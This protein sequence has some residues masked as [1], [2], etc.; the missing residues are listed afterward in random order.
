MHLDVEGHSPEVDLLQ[1]VLEA[2]HAVHYHSR[3]EREIVSDGEGVRR[4]EVG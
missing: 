1:V 2:V 3:V 4:E